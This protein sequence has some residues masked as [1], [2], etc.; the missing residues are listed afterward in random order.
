MEL[1]R[2]VEDC[3]Y[4][5]IWAPSSNHQGKEKA[6]EKAT[7]MMFIHGGAFT[8]GAPSFTFYDGTDLVQNNDNIIVVTFM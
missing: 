5:N 7:V 2:D 1:G 3:L 8:S 4:V 6:N